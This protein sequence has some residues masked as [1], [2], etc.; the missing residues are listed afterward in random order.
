MVHITLL[1]DNG[2]STSMMVQRMQKCAAERGI[3]V[4][5]MAV[6][7]KA[8]KER[9]QVTDV[10]LLSPQVRYI[11][12]RIKAEYEPKGIAVA[13]IAPMDYGRMNGEKVL[14]QAL[15]LNEERKKA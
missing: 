11:L 1:C 2:M 6:S 13:D 9:L 10:L 14:E 7:A 5:I 3:E 4:D 12:S 8:M 15:K